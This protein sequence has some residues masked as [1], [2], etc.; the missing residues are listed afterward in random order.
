MKKLIFVCLLAAS[1]SLHAQN[2][3]LSEI[4]SLLS[5]SPDEIENFLATK[6]FQKVKVQGG[7]PVRG[8]QM[9]DGWSYQTS[10]GTELIATTALARFID[11]S[12]KTFYQLETSNSFFYS[13][14][15]N[16]L[17][18]NSYSYKGTIPKEKEANLVFS[19][20][21]HEI[22]IRMG[23]EFKLIYP[24]QITIGEEVSEISF[25]KPRK[26]VTKA[27]FTKK[28]SPKKKKQPIPAKAGTSKARTA[29]TETVEK[30]PTSAK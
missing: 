1:Q 11:T 14:L 23:S 4:E 7:A 24:Y 13:H 10:P 27:P 9:K 28:A 18:E 15:M 30:E 19:N 3:D 20:S 5:K 26:V 29:K 2:I 12:G 25:F 6:G 17:E 21:R 16:Q 22:L 8:L